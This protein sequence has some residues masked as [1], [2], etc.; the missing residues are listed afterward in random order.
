L[1][2]PLDPTSKLFYVHCFHDAQAIQIQANTLLDSLN[3]TADSNTN[4]S[5]QQ[6]LL[7]R[8]HHAFAHCGMSTIR[9]ICKLGWLGTNALALSNKE[10]D[11]P[12][13]GSCQYGKAHKRNPDT[14]TEI[15]N[16]ATTGNINKNHLHPGDQVSMDHFVVRTNGRRLESKGKEHKDQMFKGGT[17]FVDAASGKITLKFQVSLQAADTIRSKMEFERTSHSYGVRIKTYRTDN[18]VFMAQA[19]I[20]EINANQQTISFSGSGAQH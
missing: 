14:K 1:T 12:V 11:D 18:G 15:P 9:H 10:N 2:L 4:L 5:R 8:L 6:K 13:C 17:I 16:P 19:F 3:L 20:D 7:L